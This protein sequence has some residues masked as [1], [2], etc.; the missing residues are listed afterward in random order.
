[1][2]M[3]HENDFNNM[4]NNNESNKKVIKNIPKQI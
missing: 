3:C 4:I 1:M 2:M